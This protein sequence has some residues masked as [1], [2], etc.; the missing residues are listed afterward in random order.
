MYAIVLSPSHL[1]W[2]SGFARIASSFR[3]M[4][5]AFG[6]FL[7]A[8]MAS[9]SAF[10]H[11]RGSRGSAVARPMSNPGHAILIRA[12]V[13]PLIWNDLRTSLPTLAVVATG[14]KVPRRDYRLSPTLGSQT[15]LRRVGEDVRICRS[16][17]TARVKAIVGNV[18]AIKRLGPRNGRFDALPLVTHCGVRYPCVGIFTLDGRAVGAYGRSRRNQK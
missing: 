5:P 9:E 6:A 17:R 18:S 8:E 3:R 4:K 14:N 12:S 2:D 11:G 16:H 15:S 7:S 1:K 10:W 13:F